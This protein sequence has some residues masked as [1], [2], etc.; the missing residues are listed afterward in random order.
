MA[1]WEFLPRCAFFHNRMEQMPASAEVI[2]LRYCKGDNATC[3]RYMVA[4]G[5]G[6]EKVTA[7]LFPIQLERAKELLAQK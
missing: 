5:L 1:D 7:D 4:K 3:A 6:R 2:K